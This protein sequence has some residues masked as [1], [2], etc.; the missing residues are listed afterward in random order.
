VFYK[1]FKQYVQNKLKKKYQDPYDLVEG[2][3]FGVLVAAMLQPWAVQ[4][5]SR[6]LAAGQILPFYILAFIIFAL[7]WP[8]I[9]TVL[10]ALKYASRFYGDYEIIE[11]AFGYRAFRITPM[12]QEYH[13]LYYEKRPRKKE[14]IIA[15]AIIDASGTIWCVEKPGRHHHCIWHMAQYGANELEHTQG[16]L[17]NQYRFIGREAGRRLAL[18]TGQVKRTDHDRD[19]FSEDLWDTPEH[20]RYK[21]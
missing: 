11:R 16:F 4:V 17:T 3:M 5:N 10:G 14:L 21:G 1:A 13:G 7:L 2:F 18:H 19:L 9:R 12:Q 8:I 20:L 15:S 6:L